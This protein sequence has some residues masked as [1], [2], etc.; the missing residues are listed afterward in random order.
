MIIV[1]FLLA[2]I[3][4]DEYE[5]NVCLDQWMRGEGGTRRRWDRVLAE[6]ESKRRIVEIHELTSDVYPVS[7]RQTYGYACA[8]CGGKR[9]NEN[10]PVED[11][12]A[13]DTLMALAAVYADHPDYDET[14][15]A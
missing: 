8:H 10:E 4:E 3:A 11:V 9:V 12:G 7:T 13:C 2:R 1:E 15:R 14:W 6:C 5:A